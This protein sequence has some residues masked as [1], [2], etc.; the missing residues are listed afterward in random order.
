VFLLGDLLPVTQPRAYLLVFH[1]R[2][3]SEARFPFLQRNG[4]HFNV[5]IDNFAFMPEGLGLLTM[6]VDWLI[7]PIPAT[8]S[9]SSI[10]RRRRRMT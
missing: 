1:W 7:L 3:Q 6:K 4:M 2:F 8:H 9:S 5:G 10:K